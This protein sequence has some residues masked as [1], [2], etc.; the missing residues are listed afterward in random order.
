MK[1]K[2]FLLP[3]ACSLIVCLVGVVSVFG[4]V[5]KATTDTSPQQITSKNGLPMVLVPAGEFRMGSSVNEAKWIWQKIGEISTASMRKQQKEIEKHGPS[6]PRYIIIP[7]KFLKNDAFDDESPRRTVYLESFYIDPHEVTNALYGKFV[8]ATGHREPKYWNDSGRNQPNQPVIGVSWHDAVAYATWAG[9]RLP[10]EVEWEYA[11]RGGLV[12]KR[13]PWGDEALDET[14]VQRHGQNA[15]SVGSYAPNGYGLF[16]MAGSVLE[17][18]LDEYQAGAYQSD[19]QPKRPKSNP[20]V[21]G[22]VESVVK[23]Y[24]SVETERVLRGGSWSNEFYHLRVAARDGTEPT[25]MTFLIG[26]RLPRGSR[27]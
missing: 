17:W 26:L 27:I 20:F 9:K 14:K 8:E 12:G 13:Y 5:G 1:C 15:A 7:F 21:G 16:D 23:E 25:T 22:H 4:Q 2:L 18:C 11:A 3:V 10:T 6:R 19:F 24:K